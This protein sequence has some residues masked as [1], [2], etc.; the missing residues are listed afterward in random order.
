MSFEIDK[1]ALKEDYKKQ[2][3]DL[4]TYCWEFYD[5]K[6]RK[7]KDGNLYIDSMYFKWMLSC[8]EDQG[9]H[10]EGEHVIEYLLPYANMNTSDEYKIYHELLPLVK[11]LIDKSIKVDMQLP[12]C[13]KCGKIGVKIYRGY[14]SF[15]DEDEDRCNACLESTDWYVPCILDDEKNAWGY[16]S[17]PGYYCKAFYELPEADE[18]PEAPKWIQKNPD[19]GIYEEGW[20]PR[21]NSKYGNWHET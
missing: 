12:V 1:E 3:I 17:V 18:S 14:S 6:S 7:L 4:L 8:I 2:V 15:R 13:G 10:Y 19:K 16:T 5:D 20:R 21:K 11:T 9:C